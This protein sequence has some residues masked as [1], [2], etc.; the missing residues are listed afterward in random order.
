MRRG[1]FREDLYFGLNSLSLHIP[2]LSERREDI[3][4]LAQVFLKKFYAQYGKAPGR[5]SP[6]ARKLEHF[7]DEMS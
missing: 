2:S 3:R 5:I 4:V 6:G 1:A 7:A